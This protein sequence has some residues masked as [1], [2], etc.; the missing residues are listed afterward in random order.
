MMQLTSERS[1]ADTAIAAAEAAH[2]ETERLASKKFDDLLLK[3]GGMSRFNLTSGE[4]HTANPLAATHVFGFDGWEELRNYVWALHLEKPPEFTEMQ[5][6]GN[7][8]MTA[9]EKCLITKMR[10]HRG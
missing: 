2:T 10:I 8:P 9:F 6:T 4:W 1:R 7:P 5:R 3:S